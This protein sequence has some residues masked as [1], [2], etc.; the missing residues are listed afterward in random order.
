M[1]GDCEGDDGAEAPRPRSG[2][3]A[4]FRADP[5]AP[6][7]WQ[8]DP[9]IT[10]DAPRP[11]SPDASQDANR[12]ASQ[13]ATRRASRRAR[14][15]DDAAAP[16]HAL[17][18][19]TRRSV[20]GGVAS[21]SLAGAAWLI[22][23]E[24]TAGSE[25]AGASATSR[26]AEPTDA[27]ELPA[28][29]EAPAPP[30]AAQ[31]AS[32][33][34]PAW[35]VTEEN[36][37]PGTDA[38]QIPQEPAAWDKVR[39]FA[40]RTSVAAGE[41][42]TLYVG[43]AARTFEVTAYRMGFYG[44]RGGREMWRSGPR[45]GTIQAPARTDRSTNM[46]DAPW[47]PSLT[48]DTAGW[49]PGSYL[50]KLTSD[51]GGQSQI[52]LV[53]RDDERASAVHIQHDVTT[54][55]AYNK[56]GGA[57]LYEGSGGRS[58]VVSFDRPYDGSG[59][60]NFLGGVYEIAALVESLGLDVTYSTSLDTH[61]RPAAV[62][63]HKVWISPAHDEYWSLEMR[64]GVEAAR[65][66]GVNLVFLG[67]NCMFRRIRL[68]DSPLGPGRHVVNYRIAKNDPL[69]AKDPSRVTSS[70]REAP[71]AEPESSLIGT[72]YES[73]PVKADM[74][75]VDADAW[76]FAGTGVKNGD[77]WKDLV[78]NEY[79]RITL[80]V[81]TPPT[82]QVL[83][84][85][86]VKVRG[87]SSFADMAYYTVPSGAGVLSTGSIWFERH[88]F[89]TTTG[90]DVPIVKMMTNV[91]QTFA[92]GPA[93]REHPARPNLAEHGIRKG[94]LR[95]IGPGPEAHSSSRRQGT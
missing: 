74:V 88:L 15:E 77:R 44:G 25:T 7:A 51:N 43:T 79:D 52:P 92:A 95:P 59:S 4:A 65:D 30:A 83:A 3:S 61:A 22:V 26:P 70:W 1:E 81:P 23:R 53:V 90:P 6:E 78:G 29:G 56:W 18:T 17:P 93:G 24:S 66:A 50:L 67:A 35:S 85:S 11:S 28:P 73:N 64:R 68:E 5:F 41:P 75:I 13:G 63:R 89:P 42:L 31:P 16:E 91:L 12:N 32:V 84:H 20:L 76:M 86:P 19:W 72:Y 38:W 9:T 49:V 54:W 10:R 71:A 62:Q 80:E 60:G 87:Q 21:V 36:Q 40:N 47:Q 48:V 82:I 69:Y 45:P 33:A 2:A 46:R 39:G 27:G 58:N 57:S 55:Q 37:R 14:R 8:P 94:Y 34:T